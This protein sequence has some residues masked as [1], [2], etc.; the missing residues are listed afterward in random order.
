M[1]WKILSI[2]TWQWLVFGIKK[3]HLISFLKF[4]NYLGTVVFIFFGTLVSFFRN[5]VLVFVHI[6]SY[7]LFSLLITVTFQQIC[8]SALLKCALSKKNI[9]NCLLSLIIS[10]QSLVKQN[11]ITECECSMLIA[12]TLKCMIMTSLDFYWHWRAAGFNYY[13]YSTQLSLLLLLWPV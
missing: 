2:F 3:G 6:H 11:S 13:T 12:L 9:H 5:K 4:L 8:S 10:A 1:C 7:Q